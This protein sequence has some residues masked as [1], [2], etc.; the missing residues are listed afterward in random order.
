MAGVPADSEAIIP[1]TEEEVQL[2]LYPRVM[3]NPANVEL[4]DDAPLRGNPRGVR[5][6]PERN[7]YVL[8]HHDGFHCTFVASGRSMSRQG[9]SA[10]RQVW[11]R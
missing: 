9:R 2:M 8:G 7:Q 1:A 10:S 5:D 11:R 4:S 6:L 3:G